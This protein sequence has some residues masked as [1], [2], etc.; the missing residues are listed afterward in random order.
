MVFGVSQYEEQLTVGPVRI[1]RQAKLAAPVTLRHLFQ[2]RTQTLGVENQGASVAAQQIAPVR[3][4]L[5]EVVV[6]L[7][8]WRRNVARRV[9]MEDRAD[10]VVSG[11]RCL[12]T[13]GRSTIIHEG[14]KKNF[15]IT[16]EHLAVVMI[17]YPGYFWSAYQIYQSV[18]YQC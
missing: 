10:G 16:G 15:N 13:G 11:R 12:G 17:R 14:V 8:V 5:A 6:I 3:A 1:V 18:G 4:N 7:R 2:L 9:W